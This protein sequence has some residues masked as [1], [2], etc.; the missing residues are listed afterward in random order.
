MAGTTGLEPATSA[1]TVAKATTGASGISRLRVRL[2]ELVGFV[3]SHRD[4]LFNVL[5]NAVR[6]I[7][8][9]ERLT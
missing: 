7:P 6:M 3:G 8:E 4:G 9:I 1:M 2:A 5:F